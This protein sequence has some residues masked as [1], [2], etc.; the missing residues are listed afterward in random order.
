MEVDQTPSKRRRLPWVWIGLAVVL[1]AGGILMTQE[2]ASPYAFLNKYQV[3][4]KRS[5]EDGK[6]RILVLKA[7]VNAIWGDIQSEFRGRRVFAS[8]GSLALNGSLTEY[9]SLGTDEGLIKVSNDLAFANDGFG[10]T[11]RDP[12]VKPGYCAVAFTRPKT[13]F[14]KAVDWIR[15]LFGTPPPPKTQ[16]PQLDPIHV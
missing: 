14:D 11:L 12:E 15:N 1:I 9:K 13:I 5:S 10:T 16:Q 8:S 3:A 4:E 6:L 2:A 7:D